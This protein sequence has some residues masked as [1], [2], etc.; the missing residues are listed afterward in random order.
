MAPG[1][2]DLAEPQM[3]SPSTCGAGAMYMLALRS[4]RTPR[5]AAC[6][7]EHSNH[8]ATTRRRST[9]S[10]AAPRRARAGRDGQIADN[11]RVDED[12]ASK[13]ETGLLYDDAFR[14]RHGARRPAAPSGCPPAVARGRD[15][16]APSRAA[17]QKEVLQVPGTGD[18]GCGHTVPGLTTD[19]P[20]SDG[21]HGSTAGRSFQSRPLTA[22]PVR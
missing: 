13:V 19:R 17:A 3:G 16:G 7:T 20:R 21:C 8:G 18:P 5:S 11:E 2:R 14:R 15:R 22:A 1:R 9:L 12:G 4:N 6:A 10:R